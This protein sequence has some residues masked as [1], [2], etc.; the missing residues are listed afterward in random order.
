MDMAHRTPPERPANRAE[1]ET[2]AY[3]WYVA[4]VLCLAHMVAMVDRFVMVLVSEPVRA[5][6]HL[7]DT[8]LG[9]LQGTG[10]SLLY[11]GFAI[12]LGA[13]AD[14]TN[15]RNLILFGLAVWSV[16]TIMAATASSFAGLF[17]ARILVGMGEACLI[18]A[19]M[20]LLATYFAPAT[21]ARG[22]AVFGMGANFG[23]GLAFLGGGIVLAALQAAGGLPVPGLGR[24]QPWQGV[25]LLAGLLALPVLVLLCWLREPPRAR[26]NG[27]IA[28]AHAGLSYLLGNLK[29]YAP[30][31]GLAAMT[32]VTGYTLNSWSSSLFVRVHGMTAAG[33]GQMIG[34][35]GLLAGPLGTIGG[36]IVL[37]R[38]RARGVAGAPLLVMAGGSVVALLTAAGIAYAP[39]LPVAILLFCLFMV[40]S[41]FTLPSIYAGMQLLTPPAFRGVA[42]SFNMMIYTLAGLGIGPAAVGAISDRLR[43]PLALAEAIVIVE[44]AMALLIVPIALAAR[45]AYQRR[46]AALA[47]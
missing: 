21:L 16:A 9:L 30:F 18:P 34:L 11:C 22:T 10:F 43:G 7:T 6:L 27:G 1:Y 46:V 47:G 41:T 44:A 2:G 37:D 4:G 3:K 19:G 29:G 32:A 23:L 40:E 17:A 38:L 36:G 14:A 13:I 25:F 31:L 5:A 45:H 42:A 24:V 8:Q 20:S 15:R 12:P 28:A 26:C 39:G 33:A 35:V